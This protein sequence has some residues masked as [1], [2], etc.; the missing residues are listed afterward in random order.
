MVKKILIPLD[1]SAP[2]ECVLPHAVRMAHAFHAQVTLLH[3]LEAESSLIQPIDPLNWYLHKIESSTYLSKISEFMRNY[4]LP[5]KQVQLEGPV[6]LRI[7]DYAEANDYDLMILSSHG[8]SGLSEWGIGST[9]QKIIQR[10]KTSV[11]LVRAF[12]ELDYLE[13]VA[14]YKRI[15]VPLD[16]SLR[17]E[18]ILPQVIVLA[19]VCQATLIFTHVVARP[20]LFS[21]FPPPRKDI[22]LV[23][24]LVEQNMAAATAYLEQLGAEVAVA[25]ESRLLV[26]DNVPLALHELVEKEEID[27]VAL[28]AHGRSCNP[29]QRCGSLVSNF[30]HFGSTPLL[31]RQDLSPKQMKQ[32]IA[33]LASINNNL[34]WLQRMAHERGPAT[35]LTTAG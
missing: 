15:L 34:Y 5:V 10:V 14:Q 33:E 29:Q 12:G 8:Q 35:P 11:M 31:I 19:Q 6:S 7:I 16:G 27:L 25:S 32:T 21:H 23:E 17:A 24:K 4:D 26:A 3:V 22:R 13:T 9:A 20:F 18:C 2:A 1:G 30:V 28:S